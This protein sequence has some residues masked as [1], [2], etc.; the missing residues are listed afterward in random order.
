M[1]A[2][3]RV[4]RSPGAT[5]DVVASATTQ[6]PDA[7]KPGSERAVTDVPGY[8]VKAKS[9]LLDRGLD[10]VVHASG[11][12]PVF[13]FIQ[14]LLLAWAFLGIPFHKTT[15]WPVVI[16]DAQAIFSYIF[17]SFL[18]RQQLN[19]YNE[20]LTVV[21]EVRSRSRSTKRMLEIVTNQL[22]GN[23]Q[24]I[25]RAMESQPLIEVQLP[26]ESFFTKCITWSA[27]ALGS[28][29][30]VVFYWACIFVWLGLGPLNG[31]S[32][33][34][35]LDIN[36]ATSA[37][38]V[39]IFSFLAILRERHTDYLRSCLDAIYRVDGLLEIKLRQ[40][41]GDE[42]PN[43]ETI[44][45]SLKINVIQRAITYY[46]DVVGTLVGIA[47]L[48]IVLI[49][50]A[51][52]GPALHFN[53]NWWLLIGTYAGLI[54]LNDGFILRNMQALH[55]RH[56]DPVFRAIETEDD[57]LF[58]SL[59]LPSSTEVPVQTTTM[60]YKVSE[61]M[62]RICGHEV[63]VLLGVI[64]LVALLVGASI[65]HWSETGQLICNIP[66]SIIESF[67]MVILI[68]GHN[69]SDKLRRIDMQNLFERRRMLLAFVGATE[70]WLK[71]N[72]KFGQTTEVLAD[73]R[74]YVCV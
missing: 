2:F 11:S 20:N 34:W 55:R 27:N 50:W 21:A 13:I 7:S 41:T 37:L 28:I 71:G 58:K 18:M 40:M 68:T 53:A 74:V 69:A 35:Q 52:I 26:K 30:F 5:R 67:F 57:E 32:N 61:R 1:S 44:I 63:T 4:L 73:E 51:C 66:P 38:M 6:Y 17:D 45:P 65:M 33:Q 25:A 23:V 22:D 62:N 24:Q 19:G 56:E 29:L 8:T 47:L 16:S 14:S 42:I 72:S 31:W 60:S 12:A 64:L 43:D 9:G 3:L 70:D 10:Y 54:G 49:V 39:F 48:V 36:S 46:A 15:I 59:G